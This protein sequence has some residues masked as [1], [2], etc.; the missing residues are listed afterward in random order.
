MNMLKFTHT[1]KYSSVYVEHIQ[2]TRRVS[3]QE[4]KEPASNSITV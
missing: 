2:N 1:R 4:M 3:R